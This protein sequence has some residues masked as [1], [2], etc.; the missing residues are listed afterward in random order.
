MIVFG[1]LDYFHANC[2]LT[3]M[4]FTK[5]K[6]MYIEEKTTKT[7]KSKQTSIAKVRNPVRTVASL[8]T[9]LIFHYFKLQTTFLSGLKVVTNEKG[10]ASGAVL[11]IRY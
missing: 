11:T 4:G 1:V 6:R 7:L 10:E 3:C 9:P 8:P 2:L 5:R